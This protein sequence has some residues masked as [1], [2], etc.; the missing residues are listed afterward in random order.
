[1]S[2]I[3][4]STK[5]VTIK[6]VAATTYNPRKLT[7]KQYNDLKKSLEKFNLAEIPAVN[8]DMTIL[9]GHQRIKIL[10]ELYGEEYE[11]DVRVPDRQL[12]KK[13]ADEYLIRSNKNTGEWDFDV[14]ADNFEMEDLEDWGFEEEELVGFEDDEEDKERDVKEDEVP[15][16]KKESI[17]KRGDVWL[18]GKHRLMCGDSTIVSDVDTLM[19][20]NKVDIILTDPPY[21]IDIAKSGNIGGDNAFGKGSEKKGKKIKAREY[22]KSDWDKE[23]PNKDFFDLL[24]SISDKQIIFGG[25]YF[26]D[27]LPQSKHWV[28][29]DKVVGEGTTFSKAELIYTNG[30]KRSNVELI[31]SQFSGLCGKEKERFH[32]TQKPIKV[33]SKLIETYVE[34]EDAVLDLFLGSGSTLIACEQ[35]ERVCFGMELD[36]YYCQVIIDRYINFKENKGEDVFLIREGEKV[37]YK[38]MVS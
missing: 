8:K 10:S 2:N 35:T 38:Q 36:E 26:A 18:L 5:T 37:N 27:I 20:G 30:F 31:R 6:D 19:D 24:L 29:W 12:T 22:Q 7:T 33:L 28:V 17:V 13:E 16:L 34:K 11:I 4:W 23:R 9:A 21:G 3:K 15:E 25:N 1:M 32:P 14:L